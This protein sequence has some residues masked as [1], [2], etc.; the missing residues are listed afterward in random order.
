MMQ[1]FVFLVFLAPETA[2]AA[3]QKEIGRLDGTWTV[4]A[5]EYKGKNVDRFPVERVIF[6]AGKAG[7]EA[8]KRKG[9]RV[10]TY[11]LDPAKSPKVIEATSAGDGGK[12]R[13]M[14]GIYEVGDDTL[15]LCLIPSGTKPPKGFKT[16]PDD[17]TMT[18]E[19]KRDK[20]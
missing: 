8:A 17:E 18:L 19:L 1:A 4:T 6:A 10:F 12:G 13:G 16:R 2:D 7:D 11:R 9:A 14:I 5:A 20:R 3:A 15:K